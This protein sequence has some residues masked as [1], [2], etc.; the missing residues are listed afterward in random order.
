MSLTPNLNL[1]I[2]DKDS[3]PTYLVDHNNDMTAID[4]GYAALKLSTDTASTNVAGLTTQVNTVQ[5]LAESASALA[6]QANENSSHASAD[7]SAAVAAANNAN[8]EA[9]KAVA[10]TEGLVNINDIEI[11]ATNINITRSKVQVVNGVLCGCFTGT[12]PTTATAS[13]SLNYNISGVVG[14]FVRYSPTTGAL[15]Q[16]A[17]TLLTD[18]DGTIANASDVNQVVTV[19]FSAPWDP[20]WTKKTNS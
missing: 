16:C 19:T 12:S 20:A 1:H 17:C 18:G 7:A 6:T 3:K 10:A 9:A 8:T 15:Y 13:Y 2:Y 4:Q 11:T 14:T 5:Q